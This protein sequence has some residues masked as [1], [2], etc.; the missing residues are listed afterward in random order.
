MKAT[1]YFDGGTAPTNPGRCTAGAVLLIN[2]TRKEYSQVLGEGSNNSA[3]YG[4][5]ILGLTKAIAEGVTDIEVLGDSDLVV[6]CVNGEWGSKQ[7]H[8]SIAIQYCRLLL[9][10]FNSWS[11]TWIP[12]AG[13]IADALTRQSPKA[14]FIQP[15]K[16][17]ARSIDK[18]KKVM[19]K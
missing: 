15:V 10:Q 2:D 19:V 7:A 12:R 4:G 3:E 16:L 1:L 18:A 17:A 6:R 13:N 8:L 11:L 14:T 9:S 5:L